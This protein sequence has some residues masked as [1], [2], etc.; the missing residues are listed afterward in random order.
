[1][2]E[3]GV[4][5]ALLETVERSAADAGLQ[6]VRRLYVELGADAAVSPAALSFAF[7]AASR[8][9][10]AEGAEVLLSGPGARPEAG[11][12]S[13]GPILADTA[14]RLTWIEGE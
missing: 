3:F 2:H 6:R 9:T 8:G 5:R 13:H 12:G 10:L 14:V 4:A 1:V 11:Q 7:A